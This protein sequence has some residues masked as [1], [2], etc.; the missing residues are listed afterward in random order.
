MVKRMVYA[1]HVELQSLAI[2][3]VFDIGDVYRSAPFSKVLAV[4]KE[5]ARFESDPFRF[6][7]F[8]IFSRSS[9]PPLSPVAVDSYFYPAG[10][11]QVDNVRITGA[12]TS[13]VVQIG[14]IDH[15][16]AVN[17]TKHF[18]ILLDER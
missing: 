14:G 8:L 12:S 2:G 3:S 11:I 17:Y 18:R 5:G 1:D 10:S 9:T 7:D 16:D 6:E 4:Q 13:A 15:I